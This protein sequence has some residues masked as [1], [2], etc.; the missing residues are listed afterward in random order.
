M[1]KLNLEVG[2]FGDEVKNLH[3]NL[4]KHG[5]GIPPSEADRAFFGPATRDAVLQW[6]RNHG[7]PVTGI[8][9]EQTNATLEAAPPSNLVQPKTGGPIAPLRPAGPGT[10]P[11][12]ILG[13]EISQIF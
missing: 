1:P 9:D 4:A 12:G 3:Q 7:L 10:A 6:Q 8:V 13:P 5:L 2:A 11:T